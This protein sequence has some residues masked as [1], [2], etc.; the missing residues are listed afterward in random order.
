MR[1]KV[2]HR[3]VKRP[4]FREKIHQFRLDNGLDVWLV[5]RKG[6]IHKCAILVFDYGSLYIDFRVG[7]RR[8]T[9]PAGLAHLLEHRLFEK[10]DHSVFDRFADYGADANAFTSYSAT[11]YHFECT[12]N[13][14]ECLS[15]LLKSVQEL[16]L[17][18]EALNKEKEV[19]ICELK[20]AQEN[21]SGL[22]YRNFLNALFTSHPVK[23]DIAGTPESVKAINCETMRLAH[24]FFYRPSNAILAAVGDIEPKRFIDTV[25][26]SANEWEDKETKPQVLLPNEPRSVHK[27][28]IRSKTQMAR[29]KVA[30]GYKDSFFF[31]RRAVSKKEILRR[32]FAAEIAASC[33]FGHSSEEYQSLYLDGIVDDTFSAVYVAD[34]SFGYFVFSTDTEKPDKFI[35]R[36][37]KAIERRKKEGFKEEEFE[38][39]RRRTLGALLSRLDSLSQTTSLLVM[40]RAYDHLYLDTLKLVEELTPEDSLSVLSEV[41]TEKK[42]AVSLVSPA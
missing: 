41:C 2:R 30:L 19:V 37:K 5:Q 9:T 33:T 26:E 42:C 38:R 34:R 31:S 18:E 16:W 32:V 7:A 27:P 15:L 36:I 20:E 29:H 21:P 10:E 23:F 6:F 35:R 17:T 12:S 28:Y 3:L 25:L 14:Y 13:F 1:R 40:G 22:L 4:Q 11:G 8:Y 39:I 24:K